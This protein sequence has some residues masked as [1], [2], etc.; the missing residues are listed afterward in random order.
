MIYESHMDD[1]S[2]YVCWPNP[3]EYSFNI[4][5]TTHSAVSSNSSTVEFM[6]QLLSVICGDRQIETAIIQGEADCH[7][8]DD[9]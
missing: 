8:D 1:L 7:T 6:C 3:M 4:P 2:V 9:L 5:N